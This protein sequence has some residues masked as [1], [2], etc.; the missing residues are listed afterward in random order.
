MA[1]VERNSELRALMSLFASCARGTGGV[2]VIVGETATGKTALLDAFGELVTAAGGRVLS[3]TGSPVERDVP[4]AIVRQLVQRAA[5]A[6]EVDAQVAGLLAQAAQPEPARPAD[7]VRPRGVHAL[8]NALLDLADA[9]PLVLSVD[10]VQHTDSASLDCLCHV[11]R[12][13]RS[14]RV[15]VVLTEQPR[16]SADLS[17]VHAE[18]FSQPHFRR[19]RLAPLSQH[20]VAR[21]LVKHLGEPLGRRLAPACVAAVGGNPLLVRALIEDNRTAGAGAGSSAAGD[22]L[23]T[24]DAFGQAVLTYLHRADTLTLAVARAIAV[25]GDLSSPALL[26]RLLD[27]DADTVAREIHALTEG[28]L[29]AAG[30][31]RHAATRSIVLHALSPAARAGL[32]RRVAQLLHDEGASAMLVSQHLFAVED[33]KDAWAADVLREAAEQQLDNDHVDTAIECLD[34]A[35]QFCADERTLA[36]ITAVRAR[37]TWRVSPSAAARHLGQLRTAMRQGLLCRSSVTA[38]LG[39]LLW[40]GRL[41]EAAEAFEWI[42]ESV[43]AA[44]NRGADELRIIGLWLSC[45]HPR[46]LA[47]LPR[48]DTTA[49]AEQMGP[50]V[51]IDPQF[52]AVAVLAATLSRGAD[53]DLVTGAEQVLQLS[54]LTDRTL[55]RVK[56]ALMA[57]IYADQLDK[58]AHWSNVL[59]REASGRQAPTWQGMLAAVRATVS[60]RRGDL[61]AA[62]DEVTW[63]FHRISPRAWGVAVGLPLA[64]LVLALT[65]MGRYDEAA[66]QLRMPVPDVMFQTRFGLHYLQA[67]GQYFLAT[68]HA[69]AALGDFLACGE[70]AVSW[71]MDLPALVPWRSDAATAWLRLGKPERARKLVE[72]QLTK[73]GAE[74]S[75]SHGLSLR[76]LATTL[77]PSERPRLLI[78]AAE[79]LRAS[80]DRLELARALAELSWAHEALGE[81]GRARATGRQAWAAARDCGAQP[82]CAKLLPDPTDADLAVPLQVTSDEQPAAALTDAELRVATL[83]A[84]GKTNRQIAHTLYITVSTVEQHLTRVYRKLSVQRRTDL[85]PCL[86]LNEPDRV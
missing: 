14:A 45:T 64:N 16:P 9:G 67:R 40:F 3:A 82:L 38:M 60:F 62:A 74:P 39:D 48:Q 32:H 35:R 30:R 76:V 79:E 73:L 49:V 27:I 85:A 24:G 71:N 47:R 10:D 46:F 58:A 75:R 18:L 7:P 31:F 51:T 53:E 15:L 63:S 20:G 11:I 2:A 57:L 33:T 12:R 6:P 4:L 52:Q 5:L 84:Q 44:D 19:I 37:A 78:R 77:D 29:L 83:A 23:T 68:G 17:S 70:M 55:G 22:E 42:R 86:P 56:V 72:D 66:A 34:R 8:G 36:E 81:H 61:A 54:R 21:L 26:G 13:V 59:L 50:A 1:L 25:L 41:D 43:H 65:A 80:G 69:Q 28:G